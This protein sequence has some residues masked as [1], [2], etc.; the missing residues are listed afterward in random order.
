MRKISR[1]SFLYRYA[2]WG[3]RKFKVHSKIDSCQLWGKVL[4]QTFWFLFIGAVL[5]AL[6]VPTSIFLLEWSGLKE[7]SVLGSLGLAFFT[8]E[9]IVSCLVGTFIG[10]T[11]WLDY[12]EGQRLKR[13]SSEA[14]LP[15]S[16]I[17]GLKQL[18]RNF[19]DK[20]CEQIEVQ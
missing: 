13:Q 5:I 7:R 1:T 9:I 6:I 3:D 20:V 8:A 2:S 16:N 17:F 12:R 18:W 14:F 10:F 4:G 15:K 11:A 19:K